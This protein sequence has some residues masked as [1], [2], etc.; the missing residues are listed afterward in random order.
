M[1]CN[2]VAS[3]AIIGRDNHVTTRSASHPFPS[4]PPLL[5]SPV[6][7]DPTSLPQCCLVPRKCEPVS[8]PCFGFNYHKFEGNKVFNYYY[9]TVQLYFFLE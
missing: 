3:R 8:V 9:V 7:V 2:L 1:F 5:P 6:S 4:P